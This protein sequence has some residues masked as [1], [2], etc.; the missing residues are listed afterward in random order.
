MNQRIREL[1]K[2]STFLMPEEES[3]EYFASLLVNDIFEQV[4]KDLVKFMEAH[5]Y[6]GSSHRTIDMGYEQQPDW[7]NMDEIREYLPGAIDR[8]KKQFQESV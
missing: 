3:V 8:I 6:S 7:V 5:T 1:A 2:Q 4:K